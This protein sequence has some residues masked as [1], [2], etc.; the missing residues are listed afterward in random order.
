M[1]CARKGATFSISELT[2]LI[3]GRYVNLNSIEF[4]MLTSHS[5][6]NVEQRRAAFFRVENRLGT[7]DTSKL[8]RVYGNMNREDAYDE[9]LEWGK[10]AFEDMLEHKHSVF[11]EANMR[12][13]LI[14]SR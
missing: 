6:E 3:H 10:V 8:P 1:E 5:K 9:G 14:N 4:I 12:Y 13:V 11:A 2:N 7:S